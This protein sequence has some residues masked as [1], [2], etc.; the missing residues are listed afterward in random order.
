MS[1]K[2]F[3]LVTLLL[4]VSMVMAACAQPVPISP[5]EVEDTATD[6]GAASEEAAAEDA[7]SEITPGGVWTIAS[8]ADASILNPILSSDSASSAI[9]QF[10]FPTLLGTDPFSGATVPTQ[11]AESWTVSDDSLTWTFNLRQ[12][13]MWSD[14]DAVDANDFKFTY[15][16]IASDLVETPRK[17]NV[18]GI[19]SINVVDDNTLEVTFKELKCDGLLDLG[20]GWLPSHL[21]ADDFSDVMESGMNESPSVSAGQFIFSSWTRD[22]N[23]VMLRNESYWE[24]SP[25]MDGTITKVVPDP[26][27]RLAQLQSGE[28]STMGLQPEQIEIVESNDS[29]NI[30]NFFD[31]GYSYIGLN[32]ANP[33]NPQAGQDEEGNYIEQEPHP[34]LSDHAVRLAMAHSLDY[35]SIIENV[36]LGQGYQIASNVLPAVG[37]AHDPSIEPYAYDPDAAAAILDEAGWELNADGIREKDGQTLSLTLITNA[38]NTTREDLGALVQDQLNSL[39]FDIT[40]EAI[41]F[42]TLVGQLLGQTFDMVIIGWTGLGTDPN[43][44]SFWHSK[45][46]TPESGFNFVSYQNPEIDRLLDEGIAVPGCAPEDRAPIYAEIQQIIH[47]DIPYLF[48]TG[49]VGN[50]GYSAGWGNIDPGEWSFSW[51]IHT[52]YD[53]A[54]QP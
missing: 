31:D 49:S 13:V 28:I 10:I 16:A 42:G 39:G 45:F 21:Y 52:W 41:D 25:H 6:T 48:V 15:D 14:G 9:H 46:D 2:L 18:A 19:E 51:N 26:G 36:Y 47:D 24:G 43:D 53:V 54:L 23:I 40:F 12:G 34:I 37:W 17:S 7:P 22:D 3:S 20:L 44:D 27:A 5:A 8:S 33:E 30:H 4:V 11:M 1:R 38:G 50:T 32:L 29:L 35:E